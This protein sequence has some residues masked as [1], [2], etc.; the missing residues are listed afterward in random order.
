MRYTGVQFTVEKELDNILPFSDINICK[1]NNG[2]LSFKA[3]RKQTSDVR[4]LDYHSYDTM[5]YKINTIKAFSDDRI[6]YAQMKVQN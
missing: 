6:P 3:F 1:Q 5:S 2:S 4:Y